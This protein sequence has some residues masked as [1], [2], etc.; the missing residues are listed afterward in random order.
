MVC[1]SIFNHPISKSPNDGGRTEIPYRTMCHAHAFQEARGHEVERAYYV[2]DL[3]K[4][5][6]DSDFL[7]KLN[8][9]SLNRPAPDRSNLAQA[10]IEVSL[11]RKNRKNRKK[12]TK[13]GTGQQQDSVTGP[14]TG[15]P[16]NGFQNGVRNS[17]Q[18]GARNSFQEGARNSYQEG[19]RNKFQKG[20]RNKFQNGARNKFQNGARNQFQ[21]GARYN[22][23]YGARNTY[24]QPALDVP[25]SSDSQYQYQTSS[26]KQGHEVL[27][28]LYPDEARSYSGRGRG[29]H[30]KRDATVHNLNFANSLIT[31]PAQCHSLGIMT[32]TTGIEKSASVE[33]FTSFLFCFFYNHE[34]PTRLTDL[35][36]GLDKILSHTWK[37]LLVL[38]PSI[39]VQRFYH[40]IQTAYK[41]NKTNKPAL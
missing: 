27:G 9:D 10:E 17:F 21:N 37:A 12:K 28:G 39:T 29:A 30:H 31:D 15:Y 32:T 3:Q 35:R 13:E 34:T 20:A 40:R 16:R 24:F 18:E 8:E 14:N 23:Q 26:S 22:V 6:Q 2:S 1:V 4:L 41:M 33:L 7:T 11:P 25:A 36:T 5:A 38:I 19:A